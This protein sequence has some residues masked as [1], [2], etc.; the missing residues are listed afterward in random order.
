MKVTFSA[1]LEIASNP[2]EPL[3]AKRSK[4]YPL[5]Y[6]SLLF[7][8]FLLSI[9]ENIAS[10]FLDEVGLTLI[11]GTLIIN[12]TINIKLTNPIL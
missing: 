2:S 11:I 3:P 6:M 1:P 9:I 4:K 10:R 12:R 5:E 7:F 8:I